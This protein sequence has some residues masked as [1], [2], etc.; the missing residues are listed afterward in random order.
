MCHLFD[1]ARTMRHAAAETARDNLREWRRVAP[2]K[3]GGAARR[4]PPSHANWLALDSGRAAASGDSTHPVARRILYRTRRLP[5]ERELFS[6]AQSIWRLNQ[7]SESTRM[8][9]TERWEV[10]AANV[11][12]YNPAPQSS[13]LAKTWRYASIELQLLTTTNPFENEKTQGITIRTA[14]RTQDKTSSH[15]K[16]TT[17]LKTNCA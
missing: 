11:T 17:I 1:C 8:R 13:Q 5:W 6:Y 3:D 9:A 2:E 16:N 14:T 7:E 4:P 12:R 15:K 10:L